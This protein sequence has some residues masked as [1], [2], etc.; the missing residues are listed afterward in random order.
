MRLLDVGAHWGT[1]T[2]AASHF[3]GNSAEIVCVEPS[4]AVV[5][6]LRANLELNQ[7]E[8]NVRVVQAAAGPQDSMLQMLTTGAGGLDFFVVPH[9]IRSDT[10]T[11]KQVSLTNLCNGLNFSP[12]HLKIDVEGFEEEV[13]CGAIGL[14]LACRPIIFLE[15]HGHL[16]PD[17]GR[18]VLN[19]LLSAGYSRWY[20]AG[21]LTNASELEK[22]RVARLM[23]LPD[24]T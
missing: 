6:V 12:T 19:L 13:L 20:H 16:I 7:L 24:A 10:V 15:L 4:P 18:K 3:S 1:F 11:V 8:R 17:R 9:E 21:S 2:L 23:C 22:C 14:L 5:K